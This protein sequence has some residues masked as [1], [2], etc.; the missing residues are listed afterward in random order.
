MPYGLYKEVKDEIPDN[1]GVITYHYTDENT[2]GSLRLKKHCEYKSEVNQELYNSLLHTFLNRKEKRLKQVER[3]SSIDRNDM[4]Y[5]AS[6]V[7]QKL[8]TKMRDYIQEPDC[9][10][11][12]YGHSC[13]NS[14]PI[15]IR[16]NTCPYGSIYRQ[17]LLKLVEKDDK[18]VTYY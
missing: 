11:P 5:D 15:Q 9:Y 13:S 12:S 17:N 4:L 8:I 18:E 14:T 10:K 2:V 7:I 6:C 3:K 1:I 16:C